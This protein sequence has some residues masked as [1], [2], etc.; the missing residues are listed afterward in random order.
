MS[1]MKPHNG[2]LTGFTHARLRQQMET[3]MTGKGMPLPH[4]SEPAGFSDAVVRHFNLM[5]GC[6]R[7]VLGICSE[8]MGVD[9]DWFYELCDEVEAE[10]SQAPTHPLKFIRKLP[11]V[12]VVRTVL[13]VYVNDEPPILHVSHTLMRLYLIG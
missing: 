2:K 9:P 4:S 13:C 10:S 6:A 12:C 8:G 11:E 1:E 7:F 5:E 3:R